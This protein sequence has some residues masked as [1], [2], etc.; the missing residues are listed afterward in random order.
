MLT[1][2]TALK[3]VERER[4]NIRPRCRSENSGVK[5]KQ[6][7]REEEKTQGLRKCSRLGPL[8]HCP[9]SPETLLPSERLTRD[10]FAPCPRNTF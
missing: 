3:V 1:T 7:L 2:I 6:E 10:A 9:I 8:D 5:T 4:K